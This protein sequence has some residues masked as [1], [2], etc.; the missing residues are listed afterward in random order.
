MSKGWYWQ[1]NFIH[2]FTLSMLYYLIK[3]AMY[4]ITLF[5]NT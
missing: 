4:F 5:N 1:V 3:S 2:E